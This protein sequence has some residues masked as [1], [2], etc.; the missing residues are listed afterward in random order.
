MKNKL[1]ELHQLVA[2]ESLL[3]LEMVA[4]AGERMSETNGTH[5]SN[6]NIGPQTNK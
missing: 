1:L 6:P 5:T 2:M 4:V 3:K